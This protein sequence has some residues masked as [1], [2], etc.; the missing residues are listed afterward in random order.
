MEPQRPQ[1]TRRKNPKTSG[2]GFPVAT[3]QRNRRWTWMDTVPESH[4]PISPITPIPDSDVTTDEHGWTR[5]RNRVR[6]LTQISQTGNR[7]P[8]MTRTRNSI[9]RLRRF[10]RLWSGVGDLV[11][12]SG[13][14]GISSFGFGCLPPNRHSQ[15]VICS[16]TCP[17][18]VTPHQHF[19]LRRG[20]LS[21]RHLALSAAFKLQIGCTALLVRIGQDRRCN[22]MYLACV[23]HRIGV[24]GGLARG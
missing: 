6:R 8:Q 10:H 20:T 5:I 18:S 13:L 3:S 24:C 4:P 17:A 12:I 14:F 21:R 2:S 11:G 19:N 1:R 9:H 23:G 22:S 16:T 7:K 15:I